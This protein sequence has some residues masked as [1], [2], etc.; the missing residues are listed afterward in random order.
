MRAAITHGFAKG[1]FIFSFSFCHKGRFQEGGGGR[2]KSPGP[3][4]KKTDNIQMYK[5]KI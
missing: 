1:N 3:L 2:V 4:S 5:Q